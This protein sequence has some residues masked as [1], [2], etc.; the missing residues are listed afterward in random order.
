[1]NDNIK[2]AIDSRLS[3]LE[4][5][6]DFKAELTQKILLKRKK[7]VRPLAVMAAACICIVIAITTIA[8]S[9]IQNNASSFYLR[10]LSTEQMAIADASAEHYGAEVYFKGLR[11]DDI[12]T[13]YFSINKLVE[14]YGDNEIRLKAINAIKPF[15]QNTDK[16]LSDAAAFSLSIL[17]KTYD[18]PNIYHLADGSI[19]FT[20]FNNYSDYGSYNELWLIKN[21]ELSQFFAFG[22]PS[23]YITSIVL[24][25]DKKNIAVTTCSNKSTYLIVFD[26]ENGLISPELI[27]S[28]RFLL[29]RDKK[30]EIWERIDHENYSGL[31]SDVKWI[32]NS[33]VEFA[34]GLSYKNTEIIENASVTYNILT[35]SMKYKLLP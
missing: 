5:T 17:T 25:P 34:A 10:Y 23:M 32:D 8:A 2:I 20:L 27:E 11:S 15:L 13:Q 35:K 14:Y 30:Y 28:A 24:S 31:Y 4:I 16:K 1:M 22:K 33:T 18:N 6:E 29:A 26:M 9:T 19:V 21:D 3:D 7:P 12:Y